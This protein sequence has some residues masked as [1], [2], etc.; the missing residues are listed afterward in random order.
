MGVAHSTAYLALKPAV[1]LLVPRKAQGAGAHSYLV[2][3][4]GKAL[5]DAAQDAREGRHLTVFPHIV[6]TVAYSGLNTVACVFEG[7]ISLT[8]GE[9]VEAFKIGVVGT[10]QNSL[11]ALVSLLLL[12]PAFVE[13]LFQTDLLSGLSEPAISPATNLTEYKAWLQTL[14]AKQVVFVESNPGMISENA[15]SFYRVLSARE[16]ASQARKELGEP[17]KGAAARGEWHKKRQRIEATLINDPA[18]REKNR[19]KMIEGLL[20]Q[21]TRDFVEAKLPLKIINGKGE[22]M[23]QPATALDLCTTLS[24]EL[25][26]EAEATAIL[27]QIHQGSCAA[28]RKHIKKQFVN[29]SVFKD[30]IVDGKGYKTT[31]LF[32]DGQRKIVITAE[33]DLKGQPDPEKQPLNVVDLGKMSGAIEIDLVA[34]TASTSFRVSEVA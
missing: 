16:A 26:N 17:P 3:P 30:L 34:R 28:L 25:G 29:S 2:M 10:L 23:C 18:W 19:S 6:Q 21:I 22:S 27:F 13:L 12:L 7:I 1:S 5:L 11:L 32:K 8:E 31:L 14:H 20:N 24:Q 33:Y 9:V 4:S 15:D